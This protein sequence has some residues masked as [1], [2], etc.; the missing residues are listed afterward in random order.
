MANIYT[1]HRSMNKHPIK[2]HAVHPHQTQPTGM[3]ESRISTTS[4]ED[5]RDVKSGWRQESWGDINR[6]ASSFA[7]VVL[8]L[9]S[10]V[11]PVSRI[12]GGGIRGVENKCESIGSLIIRAASPSAFPSLKERRK[13]SAAGTKCSP[14][15]E[16]EARDIA[17]WKAYIRPP[18][19][20]HGCIKHSGATRKMRRETRYKN[21][22]GANKALFV[23]S[24]I[25]RSRFL[26]SF[27]TCLAFLHWLTA[28]YRRSVKIL[29][30]Y[31]I[32]R[33]FETIQQMNLAIFRCTLSYLRRH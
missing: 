7:R 24:A 1:F 25:I 26:T 28:G 17:L 9:R 11:A 15:L 16:P 33:I 29:L 3:F 23:R 12:A 32:L 31:A 27:H 2:Q 21:P 10:A 14:S 6:C 13:G 20:D 30:S 18:R 4:K 22:V 5:R 19:L 8:V